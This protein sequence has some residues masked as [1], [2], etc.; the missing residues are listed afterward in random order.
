MMKEDVFAVGAG[1]EAVAP[2]DDEN[3]DCALGHAIRAH[4]RR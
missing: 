2:I 4:W 3:L 1:H